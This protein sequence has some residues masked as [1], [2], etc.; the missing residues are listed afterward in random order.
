MIETVV[1]ASGLRRFSVEEYH[2]MATAGVFG[3]DERDERVEL[4]RGVIR[5]MSPKGRRHIIAVSKAT[6]LFVLV[7]TG[8][9]RVY[10]HDPMT[11]ERLWSEPE[12]DLCI[13]SSPDPQ[14][15]GTPEAKPVLVVEVSD[16]SLEYDQTA[17]ASLYADAGI[18]EYWIVNLVNDVVEV[19]RDPGDGNYR[20]RTIAG[21]EE[22]IRPLAWPELEIK[23]RDLLP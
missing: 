17:K 4:I 20:S 16:S 22:A 10:V 9:A 23:T 1:D 8:R 7:L 5:R 11:T 21:R 12:P 19:Y 6:E 15:Y 2:R 18:P 3:R 13:V 14:T